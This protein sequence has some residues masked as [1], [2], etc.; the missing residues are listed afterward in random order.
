[1]NKH[2][3]TI[4]SHSILLSHREKKYLL[5]YNSTI[6]IISITNKYP[7]HFI[8]AV[9]HIYYIHNNSQTCYFSDLDIASSRSQ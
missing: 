2:K 6:N 7:N 3:L 8:G 5:A 9:N 1:M 4:I